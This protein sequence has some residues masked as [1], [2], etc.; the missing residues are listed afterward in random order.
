MNGSTIL[1]PEDRHDSNTRNDPTSRGELG[2][3]WALAWWVVIFGVLAAGMGLHAGPE[4]MAG[5]ALAA[6]ISLVLLTWERLGAYKGRVLDIQTVVEVRGRGRRRS[7]QLRTYATILEDGGRTR[8]ELLID[9]KVRV[10]DRVE[11][12]DGE[13]TFHRVDP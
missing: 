12:R 8:R 9:E 6:L 11:K 4:G 7:R 13:V 3:F 1:R 2:W 10:G 5:V